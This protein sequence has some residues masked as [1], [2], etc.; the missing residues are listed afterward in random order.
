MIDLLLTTK[1]NIPL[2]RDELVHRPRILD[3]LEAGLWQ[4]NS[5]RRKLTLVS[6][7]AGYGKTT[8]IAEWLRHTLS[9]SP[10][11][12]TW[13]SLDEADNDPTRFLVGL[14][15]AIQ[16]I[17]PAF[18]T[19]TG[20]LVRLPQPPP[21]EI[22]HTALVNELNAVP[23]PFILAIDDYHLIRTLPIH[24][25]LAFIL[26]HQPAH[27]HLVIMTREDPLLPI[28]RLRV[29]GQVM[30]IRQEDLCFTLQETADFLGRVMKINLS[31]KDIAALEQRTEGWIAGLQL[32]ALSMQDAHDLKG[33]VQTFTGSHR[34]ILDYLIEEVFKQ[35]SAEV[36]DFLLQTSIL[37]WLS[38]PLCDAVVDRKGSQE[39]LE[40]LE[41]ANLFLV[42]AD[43]TR[44]W[45]RYHHL[46]SELLRHRLRAPGTYDEA[47]LH[48][49]AS[50]WFEA[51]GSLVD[52][53]SHA[54]A[55]QDWGTAAR[56]IGQSSDIMLK[57]GETVTLI[58][59]FGKLPQ[60]VVCAQ[61]MLCLTY[62]WALLLASQFDTAEPLLE[63]I[64]TLAPPGSSLLGQI[65]AA[66]AYLARA[67]GDTP[68][69]IEKSRQALTLLPETDA[70]SRGNVAMNLGLAYWHEGRL[71]EAER[72]LLEAEE[73][74]RRV[75]NYYALLTVQ[76]FLARTQA[77]RGKLRQAEAMYQKIL[78]QAGEVPVLALAHYDLCTIYHEWNELQK[79]GEHLQHGLELSIRTGNKEFQNA[80]HVLRAFLLMAQGDASGAFEAVEQSHALA[81]EF[82]PATRARSAACHV[83]LALQSG[84]LDSAQHWAQQVFEGI[85]AHSFY[86]FL[87]LTQPRLLIAQGQKE[88]AAG[89]LKTCYET[90][91]HADWGYAVIA[92]LVLQAL[93]ARTNRE[94]L[95]FLTQALQ[96]AQPEGFI[97]TFADAVGRGG[98]ATRPAESLVPLLQEAALH[99]TTPDYVG[100]ILTA[101]KGK[102]SRIAAGQSALAEPLT[103]RE[104]EVLHLMTAGLSNREIAEKLFV[105]PGTAK[106]HVHNLC[107]KLGARNRTEAVMRAKELGL[108]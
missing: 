95:E 88:L 6:A 4:E 40:Q 61:P 68:R 81:Q 35:R 103:G 55:A 14:I 12:A 26:D 74:S 44:T 97:R 66:Q 2:V 87:G 108:T 27:M 10:L 67:Q 28:P 86:R 69:L 25:L 56:L 36:Q 106:T 23:V 65:A 77:T 21:A 78:Q 107:G 43:Q 38:G 82:N 92:V 16:H 60:E 100:Q 52:A 42:P 17:H 9:A 20:A 31:E 101:I 13:L 75:E 18:G 37:D 94:A 53:I 11:S 93:A 46:F 24:Q 64:E 5:F 49:R 15:T 50:Q 63:H 96:A 30:E 89:Q 70:T 79:A 32:A 73:I 76:I 29:R 105:S 7:Q 19:A 59:W 45:Y 62:I 84:D 72:A 22:I 98:S 102:Q 71:E 47:L 83:Q 85:D 41:Q 80:G 3:R 57:G 90:A 39:L 48:R 34:Y 8:L 1:F 99:G 51:Q 58:G 54:L 104:L 33:F 91:I